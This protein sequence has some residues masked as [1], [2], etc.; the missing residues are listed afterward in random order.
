MDTQ[1]IFDE[2]ERLLGKGEPFVLATVVRT[3]GSTPQKPGAK[4]LV[5]RDGS[6]VGTLGGGCVEADVWAEAKTI[7][8]GHGDAQVRRFVL[9]EDMAAKDG[10]VCGGTM[11]ILIDPLQGEVGELLPILEEITAAYEGK[12]DRALATM[13]TPGSEGAS[14]AKLF[15]RSDGSTAG[16]LGSKRLD[17]LAAETALPLMP[18]GRERWVETDD[19]IKFYVETFTCPDTV[20]I[21]GGGHVGKAV[22]DMAAFAGFRVIVVD[23]RPMYANE[24]RFPEAEEIVVDDFDRGLRSLDMTPNSYVIIATRGHKFDDVALLEAAKSKAGYVGLLGSKRKAALIYRNLIE[25][26][27]PEERVR[28][29]RSPVGLDLGGRSPEEIAVSVMAEILSVKYGRDGGSMNAAGSLVK[30][31]KEYVARRAKAAAARP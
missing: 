29:I 26:G 16:T 25:A 28:E 22:Y 1:P 20:V 12:G 8:E 24:E 3:K 23:D 17:Q 30:G 10:L 31:A 5:R 27:I 2:A 7:L 18:R 9:N 19:G 13:A 4:L 15:I 14:N 11:E 21:A 6:T